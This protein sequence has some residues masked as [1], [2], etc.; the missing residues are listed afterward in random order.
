MDVWHNL[1]RRVA[2]SKT[3]LT[4][5]GARQQRRR[6][7]VFKRSTGDRDV[8]SAGQQMKLDRYLEVYCVTFYSYFTVPKLSLKI[9]VLQYLKVTYKLLFLV[10]KVAWYTFNMRTYW[11]KYCIFHKYLLLVYTPP[12]R[13]SRV[14]PPI[15]RFQRLKR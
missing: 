6:L 14:T 13:L 3:S 15:F 10:S 4:N 1:T 9:P 5:H 12:K 8:I 7:H 2:A 11:T